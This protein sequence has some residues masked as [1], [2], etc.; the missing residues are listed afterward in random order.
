MKMRLP[1]TRR[2]FTLIELLVVIAIIGILVA[3]TTAGVMRWLNVQ[4]V[5]ETM[6]ELL[7]FDG[8][9]EAFKK[10]FGFYPPSKIMLKPNRSDYVGGSPLETQS[11]AILDKMFSSKQFTNA[12]WHGGSGLTTTEAPL[13]GDQCLV[14][15]LGGP[16]QQ[17]FAKLS[18]SNSN[19]AAPKSAV[20]ARF[21]PY[22]NF[23]SN[24]LYL[25]TGKFP[26]FMD[27]YSSPGATTGVQPYAFFS[28]GIG[29]RYDATHAHLSITNGPYYSSAAPR[30]YLRPDSFQIICAGRDRKFGLGG[31]LSALN[32]D[33]QDDQSNFSDSVLGV[34]G[35]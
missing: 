9:M 26:S 21:G 22:F 13:E 8:A 27:P 4:P 16:G 11:A 35:N 20:A 30:K 19:P 23:P 33:G 12:Q 17:G 5:K 1:G 25:R 3:L 34:S 6:K 18:D 7:A 31:L 14:F 29:G 10:D 15:F 2:G 24:R 32:A 28:T